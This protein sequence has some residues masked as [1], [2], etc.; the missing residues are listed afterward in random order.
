MGC[1]AHQE[2]FQLGKAGGFEPIMEAIEL[3]YDGKVDEARARLLEGGFSDYG[4]TPEEERRFSGL[5]VAFMDRHG[6]CAV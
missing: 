5:V 6:G 1:R 3:L 2:F 4:L